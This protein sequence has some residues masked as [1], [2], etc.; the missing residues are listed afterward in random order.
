MTWN[1]AKR[2]T[3]LAKHGLDFLDANLVLGSGIRIDIDV[4]RAGEA[5][6]MSVAYVVEALAVLVLIHVRR[7]DGPRIV[8]F[9]RASRTEE[10]VYY[11]QL[12]E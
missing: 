4:V 9:R 7:D 2:I 5:R 3:N 11:E 1:E 8:S 10:E 6:V 12:A